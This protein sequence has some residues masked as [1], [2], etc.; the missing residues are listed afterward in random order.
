MSTNV[1]RITDPAL[2]IWKVEIKQLIDA[3]I[4]SAETKAVLNDIL[5]NKVTV[6]AVV[7]VV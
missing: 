1:P 7:D 6:A 2:A 4:H 5:A 3:S